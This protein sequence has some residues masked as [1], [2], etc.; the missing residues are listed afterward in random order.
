M[1]AIIFHIERMTGSGLGA[2]KE[3]VISS[4]II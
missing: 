3:K 4:K 2:W 1:A